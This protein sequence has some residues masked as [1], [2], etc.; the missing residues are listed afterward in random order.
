MCDLEVQ[1]GVMCPLR[2]PGK[3]RAAKINIFILTLDQM[4]LCNVEG[5][6]RSDVPRELPP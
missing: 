2:F 4:T 1:V 6:T 3:I 5:V